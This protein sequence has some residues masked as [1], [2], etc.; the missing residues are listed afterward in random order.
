MKVLSQQAKT[1]LSRTG[2]DSAS[3]ELSDFDTDGFEPSFGNE[4][5]ISKF[6]PFDS[7]SRSEDDEA[8]VGESKKEKEETLIVDILEGV[9]TI[10]D[11]DSCLS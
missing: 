1:K 6:S 5:C 11:D 7:P 10:D 3:F 8:T 4:I 9:E 2:S